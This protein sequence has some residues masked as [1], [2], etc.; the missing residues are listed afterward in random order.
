MIISY[1]DYMWFAI[2]MGS[3]PLS[4]QPVVC[5]DQ[6]SFF[7]FLYHPAGTVGC[8]YVGLLCLFCVNRTEMC[9]LFYCYVLKQFCCSPIHDLKTCCLPIVSWVRATGERLCH[10]S[11]EFW[12]KVITRYYYLIFVMLVGN[13]LILIKTWWVT[14]RL[15]NSSFH[16]TLIK[17]KSINL[18]SLF[19]L[20]IK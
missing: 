7:F 6:M 18:L 12:A 15:C 11:I 1:Y 13:W 14:H 3:L 5:R 8:I 19:F 9:Q 16:T 17:I 10:F 4:V 2:S 20:I